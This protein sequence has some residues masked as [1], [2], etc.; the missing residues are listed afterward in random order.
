MK[1]IPEDWKRDDE[2]TDYKEG[3]EETF[4]EL[5]FTKIE[6]DTV[7]SCVIARMSGTLSRFCEISMLIYVI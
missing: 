2:G 4:E 7:P 1:P 6:I 3:E 5:N